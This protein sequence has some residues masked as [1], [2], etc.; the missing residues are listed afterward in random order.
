MNERKVG[1]APFFCA[2]GLMASWTGC[3][4]FPIARVLIWVGV[5][6][7]MRNSGTGQLTIQVDHRRTIPLSSNRIDT[8]FNYANVNF[9]VQYAW[10]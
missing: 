1:M 6:V 8:W 10:D 4:C 3:G 9:R 2:S 7:T 5:M